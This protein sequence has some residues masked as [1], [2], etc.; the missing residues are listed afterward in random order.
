MNTTWTA[1]RRGL[2]AAGFALGLVF[3]GCGGGDGDSA[4]PADAQP[5]AVSLKLIAFKPDSLTVKAGTT[6]TWKNEDGTE[7]SVTSGTVKQ[8]SSGVTPVTD[9]KFDSGL[10]GQTKSFTFT[11]QAPG[12][13]PYFCTL[14][15][16]TMRGEITVT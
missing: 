6:V 8:G 9:G 7:H 13:Y 12:T 4:A 1:H 14:H 3:A 5:N 10:F 15:P 2:A 16:A 11:F